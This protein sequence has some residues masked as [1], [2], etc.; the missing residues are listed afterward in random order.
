MRSR[1]WVLYKIGIIDDDAT[2]EEEKEWYDVMTSR[3]ILRLKM[4]VDI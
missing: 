4:A 1:N 2:L 3:Q